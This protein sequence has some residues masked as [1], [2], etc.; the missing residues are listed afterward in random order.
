MQ[1]YH[2]ARKSELGEILVIFDTGGFFRSPFT[3]IVWGMGKT[4]GSLWSTL[5]LHELRTFPWKRGAPQFEE[6]WMKS[7]YRK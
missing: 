3:Q 1:K 4:R 2:V 7:T 6:L 5:S